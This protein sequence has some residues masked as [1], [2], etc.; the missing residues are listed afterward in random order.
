MKALKKGEGES[1]IEILKADHKKVKKLFKDFEKL[2][3]DEKDDD[4]QKAW[5][6]E[7]ACNELTIHAEV[8]EA[9]FYPVARKVVDDMVLMDEAEVEHSVAKDLIAQL[10]EM[11]PG[12]DLYDAK[13][14]V[15]AESVRHHIK[16]E[17]NEM[18]PK[19]EKNKK[20]DL[21]AL[22]RKIMR[23]KEE[24]KAELGIEV[25]MEAPQAFR[26]SRQRSN[27]YYRAGR[28]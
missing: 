23:A 27:E 2:V 12:D 15:L 4:R 17:E 26:S 28:Y 16:E 25:E 1:A 18:F 24:M 11:E 19:L 6:V 13:F 5:L 8:E 21:E 14:L 20:L 3:E 7:Q 10:Q 22:G 9:I